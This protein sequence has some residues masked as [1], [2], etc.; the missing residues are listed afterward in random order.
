M[1][2][3]LIVVTCFAALSNVLNCALRYLTI[4]VL[5]LTVGLAKTFIF[6]IIF[7]FYL[8]MYF[9]YSN[10]Y[11]HFMNKL[12]SF[13]AEPGSIPLRNWSFLLI[14]SPIPELELNWLDPVRWELELNWNCHYLNWNWSRNSI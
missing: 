5:T 3:S 4:I 10:C 7:S 13:I 11:C 2:P 8:F 6:S 9:V 14:P 1:S 12:W